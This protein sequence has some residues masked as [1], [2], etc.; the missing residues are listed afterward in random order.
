MSSE[1]ACRSSPERAKTL[2]FVV[3]TEVDQHNGSQVLC[4][5][6]IH[7]SEPLCSV[8]QLTTFRDGT[9]R[10]VVFQ[11][12]SGWFERRHLQIYCAVRGCR[13]D[14]WARGAAMGRG[15]QVRTCLVETEDD[16]NGREWCADRPVP[17]RAVAENSRICIR[18][19]HT[20]T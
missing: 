1:E 20:S 15:Q 17:I 9:P 8:S 6:R 11:Q 2:R 3:A 5:W 18:R 12:T 7:L 4:G 19:V 16:C 14:L 10:Q 13:E